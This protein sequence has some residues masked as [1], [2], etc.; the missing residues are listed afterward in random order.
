[1]LLAIFSACLPALRMPL[2]A[3]R[4][5][6]RAEAQ[7]ARTV[8][9][10]GAAP[11]PYDFITIEPTY[12]INDPEAVQ[13]TMLEYVERSK[14]E[15]GLCYCDFST[16]RSAPDDTAPGWSFSAAAGD[17]LFVR[18]AYPDAEAVLS[19]LANVAPLRE[20]LLA[21]PAT[22]AGL[23]LHGPAAALETCRTAIS[24]ESFDDR[25]VDALKGASFFEEQGGLSRLEKVS[26]GMPL[27]LVLV[28]LQTTFTVSDA[29]AATGVCDEIVRRAE[30]EEN[31]L[32][33]G[34]TRNGDRLVCREAYGSATGLVKHVENVRDCMDSLTS[35]PATFEA[36]RLHA[37][38]GQMKTFN[39]F[40]AD[41]QRERGYCSKETKQFLAADLGYSRF[42]V[43]QSMFGFFFRK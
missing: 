40:V 16:T 33:C 35:G 4:M 15:P 19:H 30:S 43:Q 7:R 28:S 8:Q 11:Y 21:G 20:K 13:Q 29:A 42:E 12:T 25:V 5:P 9:M 10:G 34:W 2:Q 36:S 38:I 24:D 17:S 39:E 6:L 1:M 41:T 32:Y 26:G 23:E 27:P 3:Q 22:L 31:L 37:S 14:S 18:E